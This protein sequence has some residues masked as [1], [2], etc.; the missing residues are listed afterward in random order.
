M[1]VCCLK[2]ISTPFSLGRWQPRLHTCPYILSMILEV[3]KVS[4]CKWFATELFPFI[5]ST[6]CKG[7]NHPALIHPRAGF[8]LGG[9]IVSYMSLKPNHYFLAVRDSSAHTELSPLRTKILSYDFSL[10]CAHTHTLS[11]ICA[12][13]GWGANN[14]I[15]F[16]QALHMI[17]SRWG[18]GVVGWGATNVHVHLRTSTAH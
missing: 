1:L 18:W 8:K 14:F 13:R 16:T 15:K 10:V 3:I 7:W 4:I 17:M 5:Y 11:L 6:S 9:R 2:T 12:H